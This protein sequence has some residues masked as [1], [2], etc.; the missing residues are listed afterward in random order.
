MDET[1]ISN[2]HKPGNVIATKGARSV[3]KITSGE[4]GKTV[5]VVC[6]TNAAGNYIPPMM[7][8]PRKRMVDS[9][10]HNAPAGAVGLCT[11]KGWTD[12]DCFVKWLQHFTS[13]AKPSQDKK[14]IIILD[15]H[16]SHKTLQA[17]SIFASK[18]DRTAYSTSEMHSQNAATGCKF[19]QTI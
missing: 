18:W 10:M 6:A 13:I 1:G 16:H 2:V 19:F 8:F 9:L 7:I 14:H 15:G 4:K 12:E 3:G 5:T 11:T 17:V